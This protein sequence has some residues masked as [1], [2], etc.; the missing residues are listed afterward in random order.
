[1]A[2]SRRRCGFWRASPGTVIAAE[3][4]LPCGMRLPRSDGSRD[5]R[6]ESAAARQARDGAHRRIIQSISLTACRRNAPV[7]AGSGERARSDAQRG[8]AAHIAPA[9]HGRIIHAGRSADDLPAAPPWQ[10]LSLRCDSI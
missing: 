5:A 1:V 6:L 8:P 10:Q 2:Q 9:R 3:S 4:S 7:R